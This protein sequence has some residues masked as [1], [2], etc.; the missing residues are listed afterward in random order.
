MHIGKADALSRRLFLQR[1][2]SLAGLGAASSYALGLA[3]LGEA[4]AFSA[5]NDYKALVCIFL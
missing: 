3:G 5:G 2:A 1:S 4:A